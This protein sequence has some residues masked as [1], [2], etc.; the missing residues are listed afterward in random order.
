MSFRNEEVPVVAFVVEVGFDR[1]ATQS[2]TAVEAQLQVVPGGLRGDRSDV[3]VDQP[4]EG[5]R[6]RFDRI[7]T[8]RDHSV[9]P[10]DPPC[11]FYQQAERTLERSLHETQPGVGQS[12]R[13]TVFRP[14]VE[15]EQVVVFRSGDGAPAQLTAQAVEQLFDPF[16]HG[17]LW[18]ST[19][20]DGLAAIAPTTHRIH[21]RWVV[22]RNSRGLF[23]R[24]WGRDGR[25]TPELLADA[26]LMVTLATG[27][28]TDRQLDTLSWALAHRQE[29]AGLEWDWLL[30][31]A[32]ELAD[33]AP[34]FSDVR[35]RLVHGI[36]DHNDR[37]LTLTLA[38]RVASAADTVTEEEQ[39]LLRSLAA[40]FEVTEAEQ[41]ELF[42][43]TPEGA[44]AFTW[45]RTALADPT[46]PVRPFFE[47][48][49]DT[50]DPGEVR[51]L[52]HRLHAVRIL[53]DTSY[54][55]GMLKALGYQWRIDDQHLRIDGVFEAQGRTTWARTL[56]AGES[57]F[58]R[59]RALLPRLLADRPPDTD[60]LI[61]HSG[62]LS[63]A[64]RSLF[65]DLEDV[66]VETLDV[67]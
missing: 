8:R 17:P 10:V 13:A 54:R 43:P 29:L 46:A 1:Q 30:L 64:D 42:R 19:T 21:R 41:A 5:I 6:P 67:A 35:E 15:H 32:G 62:P 36:T 2:V 37:R 44:P 39:A 53:L 9:G 24:W 52:I 14:E 26:L 51:L 22:D 4:I 50:V 31:R 59:E 28:L 56:A 47:V 45:R 12:E 60:V 38:H 48:L 55:D 57:L 49:A 66:R 18:G 11:A 33:D 20:A 25:L 40:A 65:A 27:R 58:P 61:T 23:D 16:L 34:L 63:P 7:P 3:Q